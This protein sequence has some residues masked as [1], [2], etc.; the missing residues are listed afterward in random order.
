MSG[1]NIAREV[2]TPNLFQNSD[3][4]D[5]TGTRVG[6]KMAMDVVLQGG[7]VG[8][9]V[10]IDLGDKINTF[11]LYQ[12]NDLVDAA[13]SYFGLSDKDGKWL[14]KKFIDAAGTMRYANESNNP[15]VTDYSTAWT[16][17]ATLNYGLFGDL[18]N[19]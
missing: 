15:T 19:Y 1:N 9:S 11:D 12:L 4:K 2:V 17:R 18:T 16:N 13:T 3:A 7:S 8:S 6:D 14:V 5:I 10:V